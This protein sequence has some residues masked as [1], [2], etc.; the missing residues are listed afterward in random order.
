PLLTT[1]LVIIEITRHMEQLIRDNTRVKRNRLKEYKEAF[2][3]RLQIL[4][5]RVIALENRKEPARSNVFAWIVSRWKVVQ[6]V[7]ECWLGL[8]ELQT[9]IEAKLGSARI[10]FQHRGK[11]N[12]KAGRN[13]LRMLSYRDQ[14]CC[15]SWPIIQ[16]MYYHDVRYKGIQ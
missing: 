11:P 10:S 16:T 5:A 14:G 9:E 12:E 7:D 8:R 15:G 4:D 3:G 13:Y 6:E 1:L 2:K